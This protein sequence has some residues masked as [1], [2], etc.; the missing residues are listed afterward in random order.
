VKSHKSPGRQSRRPYPGRCGGSASPPTCEW[1]HLERIITC[2]APIPRGKDIESS[3]DHLRCMIQASYWLSYMSL[4]LK[5]EGFSVTL[6]NI[7]PTFMNL[8]QAFA[9]WM[10]TTLAG[11]I[12][13]PLLWTGQ[14]VSHSCPCACRAETTLGTAFSKSS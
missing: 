2:L 14:F 5:A 11:V 10:G 3:T 1:C 9:S 7:L 13:I 4:W 8:T 6:V 12:S